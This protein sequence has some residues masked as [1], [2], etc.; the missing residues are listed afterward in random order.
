MR[1]VTLTVAA[2]LFMLLLDG[3]ILNTSL[4]AMAHALEV[5]PL[6]LSAAVTVYLLTGAAVLPLASWL[7]ERFGLRRLFVLA[8]VLFTGASLLCGFAQ[9]ATQLVLAR[10]LQGLGGGLMMPVGRTLA[11]QGARKEDVIGITALLTWPALFAPVLGPPLG[12]FITTYASWRWNFLLNVPLGLLAVFLIVRW[13]PRDTQQPRRPLDVRGAV[14]AALGL[15]L[16]LGGLDWTAHVVGDRAGRL[17][18][19]LT[20]AF[21]VAALVWTVKHLKRTPH[22]VVSLAPFE[23]RT[24]LVATAAGGTFASMCLQATPFLLPLMFQLALGRGAVAAGALLLPYFLGNLGMKSVTTPILL[25][26][27]FRRVLVGAGAVN[28]L[29]IAAF[30][31]VDANTPWSALVILLA[32]AGCARSMLMTAINTLMFADVLPAQR[33]AASALSTVS[34]QAAGALG[35]AIGAIALAVAQSAHGSPH[36]ELGDFHAAFLAMAAFCAL[37][38]VSFWRLPVDA[39]AEMTR[40]TAGRAG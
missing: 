38:T 2:A 18:A 8:I 23:H 29:A 40:A 10:A 27:G 37:A 15:M 26:L 12:G 31:L 28:A 25:R 1:R 3:S 5:R 19:L 6:M 17:Q 13:V 14:G 35:V 20:L 21:G 36:L 22:P 34:M 4:P 16:L 33:A 32:V 11:M 39:G 24:F 9:D 30:A 7:G